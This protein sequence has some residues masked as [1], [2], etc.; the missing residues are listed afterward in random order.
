V[1]CDSIDA[2]QN[3]AGDLV[4]AVKA[5]A[6]EWSRA[7]NLADVVAG[8]TQVRQSQDDLVLFKSVGLAMEDVA[9][10]AHVLELAKQQGV[11]RELPW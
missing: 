11:G 8:R 7:V 9:V 10:A 5:S 2:C 6:F 4:Q 1:V 3:E